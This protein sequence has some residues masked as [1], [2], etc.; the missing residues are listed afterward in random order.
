[1]G[2]PCD[3]AH[4]AVIQDSLARA[5]MGDPA[6]ENVGLLTGQAAGVR[7]KVSGITI[8]LAHEQ[9]KFCDPKD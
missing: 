1:M 2:R 8:R 3:P 4:S 9:L 7:S 6:A 5:S